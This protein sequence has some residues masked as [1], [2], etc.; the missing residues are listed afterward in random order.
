MPYIGMGWVDSDK[1]SPIGGYGDWPEAE[2]YDLA[3]RLYDVYGSNA[4]HHIADILLHQPLKQNLNELNNTAFEQALEQHLKRNEL[5]ALI[6]PNKVSNTFSINY[7]YPTTPKVSIL[8]PTKDKLEFLK[9]CIESL[10][11]K[12]A[13]PNY[14][15]L[16]IDN[17]SEEPETLRYYNALLS[18]HG[19]TV[20]VIHYD[21]PFNFSAMNNWAAEQASGEYLLLLNNDTQIVQSTWL[22]NLMNFGQREDV[23]IV[24][25]RLFYPTSGRIQHAG[26]I[27]GMTDI[28]DHPLENNIT[29][30]DAS[31][32]NR[33]ELSQNLSA[34]TAAVML[35]RK[36][37][38]EQLGGMDEENLAV[39]FNDVDL[40]LRA[41]ELGYRI[42]Y[43]PT[44][45]VVHHGSTSLK[46]SNS[47]SFLYFPWDQYAE[48]RKRSIAERRYMMQR[49]TSQILNNDPC[50]N[51]NLSL[52]KRNYNID[53]NSP[54]RWH[55]DANLRTR[56]FGIP[57]SGGS[58]EYRLR[59][60]FDAL[61]KF[62]LV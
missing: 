36:S 54:L 38:Y 23:A 39:L 31:Y 13:Y 27:V 49:W 40:C 8:I 1:L 16:V 26:V 61:S 57:L 15:I 9:P 43:S 45:I 48:K 24:G 29:V 55:R 62:G 47:M 4:F 34:V 53:T 44:S 2:N 17:Q 3:L 46:E 11:S 33:A 6:E 21:K 41:G 56:C 50:Y 22:D 5:T 51:P 7:L 19:A 28:A 58:G 10:L 52:Q 59:Q 18:S 37:V 35:V 12:T 42:V 20:R 14:E 60:P 25:A 32:M 30:Y